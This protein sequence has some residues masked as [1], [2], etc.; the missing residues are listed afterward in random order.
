MQVI[1]NAWRGNDPGGSMKTAEDPDSPESRRFAVR[2]TEFGLVF[3]A[4]QMT[5]VVNGEVEYR[6]YPTRWVP[7]RILRWFRDQG[8]IS[9]AEC[10]GSQLSPMIP[11]W[12]KGERVC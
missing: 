2:R 11:D 12:R 1:G 6:G 4:A 10:S 5:Q 9:H 7:G 3:F 8:K